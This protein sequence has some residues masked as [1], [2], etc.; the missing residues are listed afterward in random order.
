MLEK[1]TYIHLSSAKDIVQRIE[2]LFA[3]NNQQKRYEH[4]CSVMKRIDTIAI[5][6]G[7]DREKC[8]LSAMLHDVSTLIKWQVFIPIGKRL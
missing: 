8:R 1:Y 2:L 4:I 6:Y 3:T 5:Q 7:L